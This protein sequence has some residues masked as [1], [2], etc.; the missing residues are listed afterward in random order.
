MTGIRF[1]EVKSYTQVHNP[2]EQQRR[3]TETLDD[4][5]RQEADVPDT[6]INGI[7][8]PLIN[9]L[10]R[11]AAKNN[12]MVY[13]GFSEDSQESVSM[14]AYIVNNANRNGYRDKVFQTV[15]EQMDGREEG[16]GRFG[17]TILKPSNESYHYTTLSPRC[18]SYV[19][20]A[21][22]YVY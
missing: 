15:Q 7:P 20:A 19:V 4:W 11:S 14:L 13:F 6:F 3:H 22:F 2:F 5:S 8:M 12:L 16:F 1:F 17:V 10:P 18:V 9:T 21:V